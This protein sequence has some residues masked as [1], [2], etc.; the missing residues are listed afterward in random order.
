M[1]TKA[2]HTSPINIRINSKNQ[3]CQKTLKTATQYRISQEIKSL[4]I[5]K[6]KLNKQLYKLH[7]ECA[8]KWPSTCHTI[9]ETIDQKLTL[10]MK[11][12][13]IDKHFQTI[14]TENDKET[15]TIKIF[16]DGSKS[17]QVDGEGIA[18]YRSGSHI[19]SLKYRLNKRCTK[20]QAKQ[21]AI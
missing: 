14:R 21:L 3:Q 8:H 2:T 1:S 17:D 5:K 18:I 12:L 16:T 4:H 15:S 9:L 13:C 7:P 6:S 20:N 11:T 10:E 19:K